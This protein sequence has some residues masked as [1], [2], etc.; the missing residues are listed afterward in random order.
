MRL[1]NKSLRPPPYYLIKI[2]FCKASCLITEFQ[3]SHSLKDYIPKPDD[4][5][6]NWAQNPLT[7]ATAHAGEMMGIATVTPTATAE[8]LRHSS[9][10]TRT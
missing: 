4:A 9:F 1:S 5:R 7:Y 8:D 3:Y 6:L 10:A 2:F